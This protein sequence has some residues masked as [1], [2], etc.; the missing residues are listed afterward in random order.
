[1]KNVQAEINQ[2]FKNMLRTYPGWQSVKNV[3]VLPIF[4]CVV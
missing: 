2:N 1:M 4:V 3:S